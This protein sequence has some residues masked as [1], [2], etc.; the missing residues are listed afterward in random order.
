MSMNDPMQSWVNDLLKMLGGAGGGGAWLEIARSMA[1]S[2]ATDGEPE[3][4]PDPLER[5]RLEELARVAELH[6]SQVTGLTTAAGGRA[7]AFTA[8]GRGVW[9]QRAVAAYQPWVE[10]LAAS[11]EAGAPAGGDAV[12]PDLPDFPDL[13]GGGVE[14]LM[15]R[16]AGAAGPLI[17]GSQFGSAI[18]H[19]ARRALGQ[20]ALPLS[21]PD[22]DLLV[23]PQNVTA[24]IDDWSLPQDNADLWVCVHELTSHAVLTLP[25]VRAAIARQLD[26]LVSETAGMQR[27]LLDRLAGQAGDPESLQHLMEDPESLLADL[28]VPDR[29]NTSDRLTALTTAVG[30]YVDHVT[31]QVVT[32]LTGSTGTVSEAWYRYR[33]A[34]DAPEQ[35]AGALLGLDVGREQVDRGA[36]FV[37]GVCERAGDDGLARLWESEHTLPTPAEV[38]APGLWLERI[39]LPELGRS[40]EAQGPDPD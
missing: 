17:V 6:V 27:S 14:E 37:A 30:G 12:L 26:S 16:I 32:A 4:N 40:G 20:Y 39:S 36:A 10:Q 5:M 31:A 22:G 21:W 34:E 3:A 13:G 29:H 1:Y 7:A 35:A 23:V 28:M 38:D 11:L 2:V 19:L 18:G 24:F 25:H 8:V 33:V 9:A 15:G